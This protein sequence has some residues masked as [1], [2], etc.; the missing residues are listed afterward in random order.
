MIVPRQVPRAT[1]GATLLALA[2][3][4]GVTSE[5]W[6]DFFPVFDPGGDE[7][8]RYRSPLTEIG[9]GIG[10]G[11]GDYLFAIQGRELTPATNPFQ[12][13]REAGRGPLELTVGS[14]A[15]GRAPLIDGGS[16]NVP[17][18]G[19]ADPIKTP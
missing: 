14:S 11:V 6:N 3:L 18:A 5:L 2:A 15:D 17:E 4:A 9:V 7:E 16:V 12:L 8:P 13:L 10:V 1:L 19:S